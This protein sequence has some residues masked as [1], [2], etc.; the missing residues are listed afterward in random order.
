MLSANVANIWLDSENNQ[1]RYPKLQL[2]QIGDVFYAP[3]QSSLQIYQMYQSHESQRG[4]LMP[5]DLVP[6][7]KVTKKIKQIQISAI[8]RC[9]LYLTN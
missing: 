8:S 6:L 5:I 4:Q 7:N 1:C 3:N 2:V 9:L